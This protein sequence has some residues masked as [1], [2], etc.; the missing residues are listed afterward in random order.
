MVNR[1]G[2]TVNEAAD[3]DVTPIRLAYIDV[4][5]RASPAAR[6]VADRLW[7]RIAT[8]QWKLEWYLPLWLGD[9]YGLDR[10]L[11]G[12]IVLSNVLGLAA[13]RL[14]DDLDDE[15]V[16]PEDAHQSRTLARALYEAALDVYRLLLPNVPE[17][18]AELEL[19]MAL[20]RGAASGQTS[21]DSLATIGALAQRAAPLHISAFAVCNLANEAGAFREI[22]QCLDEA[23]AA[24]VMYDHGCDWPQDLA[25]GRPNAFVAACLTR[26]D[27]PFGHAAHRARVLAAMMTTTVVADYHVRVQ[28][29]LERAAS[30]AEHLRIAPL[31]E[32]LA[33]LAQGI[34]LQGTLRQQRYDLLGRQAAELIFGSR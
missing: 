1:R 14:Q 8:P 27:E 34:V 15:E 9:R 2:R 29:C 26:H 4:S 33:D 24:M 7:R 6:P 30:R 31:A 22:E 25:A 18:W 28:R 19:R 11:S 23:L 12:Q 21:S 32:H 17:F 16:A 20:W 13:V 3:L 10:R 5:E